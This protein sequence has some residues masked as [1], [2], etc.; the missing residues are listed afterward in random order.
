LCFVCCGF[1]LCALCF[2]FSVCG[3]PKLS[4]MF[5]VLA[6]AYRG[7]MCEV[8]TRKVRLVV[9]SERIGISTS[10]RWC[11]SARKFIQSIWHLRA[12]L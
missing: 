11:S 8:G 3:T 4:V 1:V 2:V 10:Q 12:H 7:W 9:I 5:Y 6:R